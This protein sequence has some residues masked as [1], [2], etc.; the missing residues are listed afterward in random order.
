M[1]AWT[2]RNRE[3]IKLKQ[4]EYRKRFKLSEKGQLAEAKYRRSSAKKAASKRWKKK[5]KAKTVAQNRLQRAVR[6]GR[7]VR[8]P[9]E[10]CRKPN[11]FGHHDDYGK[12]L[13]VRWL[14]NL[15]HTEW[16]RNNKPKG[17]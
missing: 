17:D 4:R 2:E 16:H 7:L 14:C 12:P 3:R 6:S 15:H 5:N 8:Q 11:A 10:A 13:D 9:C 1:K